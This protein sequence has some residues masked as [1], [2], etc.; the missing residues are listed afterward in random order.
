MLVRESCCLQMQICPENKATRFLCKST[1]GKSL[2]WILTSH[3]SKQCRINGIQF[4]VKKREL[5]CCLEFKRMWHEP[6]FRVKYFGIWVRTPGPHTFKQKRSF[7]NWKDINLQTLFLYTKGPQQSV[8]F[9]AWI[10]SFRVHC[11][12]SGKRKPD[13][14]TFTFSCLLCSKRDEK[15][16][17]ASEGFILNILCLTWNNI[18]KQRI[19]LNLL[20][21]SL[22]CDGVGCSVFVC[23]FRT[24]TLKILNLRALFQHRRLR[25]YTCINSG[26]INHPVSTHLI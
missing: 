13:V 4:L 25:R 6:V 17:Y 8:I 19:P 20:W 3:M 18:G 14:N 5:N 26:I 9:G 11:C 16:N 21:M 1:L 2:T 22:H 15:I 12:H 23:L 10:G 24:I 7:Y